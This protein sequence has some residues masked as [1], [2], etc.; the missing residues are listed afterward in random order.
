MCPIARLK[1]IQNF[2][3]QF[4]SS[5]DEAVQFVK[6]GRNAVTKPEYRALPTSMFLE[7]KLSVTLAHTSP[8]Y[9]EL[10]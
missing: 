7:T 3:G 2:E 10:S 1:W 9:R 4:R 6:E 8:F 5:T